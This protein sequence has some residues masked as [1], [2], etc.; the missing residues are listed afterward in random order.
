MER[1][2]RDFFPSQL[3]YFTLIYTRSII[4][5]A[6]KYFNQRNQQL[7]RTGLNNQSTFKKWNENQSNPSVLG[8]LEEFIILP[9]IYRHIYIF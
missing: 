1:F 8:N 9:G 5:L 6:F 7:H 2:A 3:L 4:E